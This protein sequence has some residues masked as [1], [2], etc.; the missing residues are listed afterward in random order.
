MKKL[1]IIIHLFLLV[2]TSS[3]YAQKMNY[4][5]ER[6]EEW[7]EKNPS[8][9]KIDIKK[10]DDAIAFAKSNEYSGSRDLRI[11]TLKSFEN[12]PFHEI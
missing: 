1:L 4:F 2:F 5:P 9:Y 7:K 8:Y 10:L 11:A 6:N 12:E 3:I